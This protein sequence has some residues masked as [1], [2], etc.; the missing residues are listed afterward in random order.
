MVG[1][2]V[3][4]SKDGHGDAD[5]VPFL[6]K[7]TL[8]MRP[9]TWTLRRRECPGEPV[10]SPASFKA[11]AWVWSEWETFG[12]GEGQCPAAALALKRVEGATSQRMQVPPGAV[13][14]K[15][16]DSPLKPGKGPM[17]ATE[18]RAP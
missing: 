1:R 3:A 17:L 15:E 2:G 8:G 4:I 16:P 12:G 9:M 6:G 10:G 13:R 7:W 14:G 18:T 11:E 5:P